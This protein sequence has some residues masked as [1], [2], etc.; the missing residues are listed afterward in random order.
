[1]DAACAHFT[2]VRH[3][4]VRCRHSGCVQYAAERSA[5]RA[6]RRDFP[7]RSIRPSTTREQAPLVLSETSGVPRRDGGRKDSYPRPGASLGTHLLKQ[8][9]RVLPIELIDWNRLPN[10]MK[11]FGLGVTVE[12][13]EQV[14]VREQFLVDL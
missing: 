9:E 5:V 3:D 10:P 6:A 4:E 14:T 1:M 11:E 2:P 13:V 12:V 7:G 8:L